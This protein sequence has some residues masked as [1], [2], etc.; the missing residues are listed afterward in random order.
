MPE[1]SLRTL[2]CYAA[3]KL[4][5]GVSPTALRLRCLDQG[6]MLHSVFVCF[7][8]QMGA[9][10]SDSYDKKS[11]EIEMEETGRRGDS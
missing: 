7:S 8:I 10:I 5:F 6:F 3:S 1:N 2:H 4:L 9:F 11:T